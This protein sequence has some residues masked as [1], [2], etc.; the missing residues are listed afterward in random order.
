MPVGPAWRKLRVAPS[1]VKGA[2]EGLF[3]TQAIAATRRSAFIEAR[4][5]QGR[6]YPKDRDYLM[7]GFGPNAHVEHQ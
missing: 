4:S 2:G 5:W 1:T 6:L 7:G 3:A